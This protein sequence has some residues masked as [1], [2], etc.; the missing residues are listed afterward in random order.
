[1]AEHSDHPDANPTGP[2]R[3]YPAHADSVNHA[4]EEAA[5]HWPH[6]RVV[7]RRDLLDPHPEW[8]LADGLHPNPIG[9]QAIVSLVHIAFHRWSPA[10][11]D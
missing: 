6:L 7:D 9:Q 1:M 8:H 3:V 4:I 10:A 5:V 2:P 11:G